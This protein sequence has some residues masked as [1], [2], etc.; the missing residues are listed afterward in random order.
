MQLCVF[1]FQQENWFAKALQE[2][3]GF[4]IKQMKEDGACLFRAVGECFLFVSNLCGSLP[5]EVH[6]F[7]NPGDSLT[8]GKGVKLLKV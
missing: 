6:G 2:K 5:T 8:R 1:T 3:K 7:T 4:I